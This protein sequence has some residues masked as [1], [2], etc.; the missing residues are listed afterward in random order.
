MKINN[1]A[2]RRYNSGC[3]PEQTFLITVR[4]HECIR[5]RSAQLQHLTVGPDWIWM[6]NICKKY[7]THAVLYPSI[8][9]TINSRLT[10]LK[11]TVHQQRT[12][13]VLE[14][15]LGSDL[16]RH[17]RGPPHDRHDD[18]SQQPEGRHLLDDHERR[19]LGDDALEELWLPPGPGAGIQ[20]KVSC[21]MSRICT[22]VT[23][24]QLKTV[25]FKVTCEL[26]TE[27]SDINTG[28]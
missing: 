5:A 20:G 3:A 7:T 23:G 4:K 25:V 28:C 1:N 19:P 8:L 18:R 14:H 22:Y 15:R 27:L 26:L 24:R 13:P 16:G 9:S 11:T 21:H 2:S 12:G 17:T 10:V 6:V